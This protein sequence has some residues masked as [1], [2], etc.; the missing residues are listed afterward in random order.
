MSLSHRDKPLDRLRQLYNILL[1]GADLTPSDTLVALVLLGAE[2]ATVRHHHIRV[3]LA[4][5]GHLQPSMYTAQAQQQQQQQQGQEERQPSHTKA[6]KQ[7]DGEQHV[8]AH[9][10]C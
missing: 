9:T 7:K 6:N 1:K 8:T 5:A 3:A 10:S 2:Q 4:Q